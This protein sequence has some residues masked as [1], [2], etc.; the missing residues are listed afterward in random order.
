ML[1]DIYKKNAQVQISLLQGHEGQIKA[2]R[3]KDTS[4]IEW[5]G[6]ERGQGSERFHTGNNP[7][8]P[9]WA[10]GSTAGEPS[11]LG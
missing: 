5:E 9:G 6:N 8:E 11:A 1:K 10:R 3:I 2:L 7:W 4:E